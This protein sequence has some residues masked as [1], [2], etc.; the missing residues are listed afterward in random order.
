MK[1]SFKIKCI[2]DC[3]KHG[4]ILFIKNQEYEVTDWICTGIDNYIRIL[5]NHGY[6]VGF[7]LLG[8]WEYGDAEFWCA[9]KFFDLTSFDKLKAFV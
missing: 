4:E 5:T 9:D 6:D 2:A 1:T 7:V 3:F 8:D